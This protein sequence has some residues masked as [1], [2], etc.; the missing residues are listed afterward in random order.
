MATVPGQVPAGSDVPAA[1]THPGEEWTCR[2]V[3][4]SS[5]RFVLHLSGS[6]QLGWAGHLAAGLAA[7]HISV[8]R[9]T[10]RRGTTRWTAEVE[11]DVLDGVV[12]PSA[13]DFLALMREHRM[14]PGPGAI[15]LASL[16]VVPTRRDLQ[17]EI[18]GEDAVGLLGRLL[19]VFAEL[20]LFPRTLR[21]ET[22]GCAVRDVFLLQDA[23]GE[24]PPSEVV[25]A[26]S[27]RLRSLVSME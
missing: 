17:V 10:A 24:P 9:A 8:V 26:L 21:A 7:R 2:L 16:R 6:L 4:K 12:E 19:L 27:R 11:F 18:R 20:G 23:K 22:V 25:A 13:I 1:R 15:E 14:A 3:S 5:R